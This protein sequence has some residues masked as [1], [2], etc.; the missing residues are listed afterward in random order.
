[1]P[2]RKR[3]ETAPEPVDSVQPDEALD[4][5]A[6][7]PAPAPKAKAKAETPPCPVCMPGGWPETATAMGCEHGQFTR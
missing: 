1:M 2:P 5:T 7:E 3:A 6:P 4:I